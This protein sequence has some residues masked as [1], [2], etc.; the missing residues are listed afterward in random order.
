M[1][2][3]LTLL[4]LI[5]GLAASQ[6]HSQG[7]PCSLGAKFSLDRIRGNIE[8]VC[9]RGDTTRAC[10]DAVLPLTEVLSEDGGPVS[11]VVYATNSIK[12]GN[13]VYEVSTGTKEG[14]CVVAGP[15]AGPRTG[16]GCNDGDNKASASCRDGCGSTQGAGSCTIKSAAP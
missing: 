9:A 16:V 12:C 4:S 2:I 6:A 5:G 8:I 10:V 7:E 15:E 1:K 13:T 11:G 3:L 14:N